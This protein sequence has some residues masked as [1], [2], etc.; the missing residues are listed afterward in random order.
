[1]R[2]WLVARR[3]QERQTSD[4]RAAPFYLSIRRG[5]GRIREFS[6][7]ALV[8]SECLR[9]NACPDGSI[10]LGEA[11]GNEIDE[12]IADYVEATIQ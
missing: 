2:L 8:P 9:Y 7:V 6:P 12:R 1:M 11:L 4:T 5:R 3:L 10:A